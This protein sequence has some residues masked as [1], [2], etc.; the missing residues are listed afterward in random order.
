MNSDLGLLI[1]RLGV[2]IVVLAHGLQKFGWLGGFGLAGTAGFFG[3]ML[4]F[5]PGTFWALVVALVETVGSGLMILGLLGPIGP[6]P[7]AA[8]MIVAMAV[9]HW[10]KGFWNQ[11]GGLE[12][13]LPIAAGALA[14][15][16]VG[17][18]RWSLDAA[19]GIALPEWV[20]PAWAA[21]VTIGAVL[22]LVSRRLAAAEAPSA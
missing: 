13:P 3:G 1:L 19:L 15:G 6:F 20:L 14:A 5:T 12:F 2:G 4:K 10:P 18:G 22:A 11:S 16:L 8:D 17:P 9:V 21:L 7:I